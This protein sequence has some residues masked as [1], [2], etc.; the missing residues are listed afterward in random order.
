MRA[1]DLVYETGSALEANRARSLLTVLGIVIG[2]AAVIAMT[3]LIGGVKESL[4]G[5]LGLGRARVVYISAY[6]E[7]MLTTDDVPRLAQGLPDYEYLTPH[8]YSWGEVTRGEKK[9]ENSSIEGVESLFFDAMGTNF[10][11][12]RSFSA[13]EEATAAQ[14][15]VVNQGAVRVLFDN[16]EEGAIGQQLSI[17]GSAYTVVGVVESANAGLSDYA[18]V[19]V[20]IKT[21]QGR[22]GSGKEV[23][24]LMGYAREDADMERIVDRTRSYLATYLGYSEED[25]RDYIYVMSTQSVMDQVNATMASFQILM[26][27]VASISLLVGGIGIMNMMLTNVTERIR[28]IGLRKALGA[29][30]SDITLQFLLESVTLCLVGGIFGIAVGYGGSFL[31]ASLAS[32]A[33]TDGA[34]ITPVIDVQSV[35][36][37]TGICIGIGVV[38]GFYPARRAAKLDPVESLH[39]Q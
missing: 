6:G 37:A 35:L 39:Y 25:A 32:D 1:R 19:W 2:I 26:T 24:E 22:L 10:I 29:R 23:G 38:F 15:C 8:V 4:M 33:L 3:A 12:G 13:Q 20:P 34:A 31:L 30:S 17:S 18:Q 7:R 36:L 14:V 27:T 5:E 21:A 28:E 9:A 11:A 16:D